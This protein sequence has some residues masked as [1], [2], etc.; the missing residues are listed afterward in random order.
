MGALP[1]PGFIGSEAQGINNKGDIVGHSFTDFGSSMIRA[2]V[3]PAGGVMQDLN[4]LIPRNSG[5]LL[6]WASKIND[7]GQIVGAGSYN[8]A[9]RAYLL[10]PETGRIRSSEYALLVTILFGLTAGEPGGVVIVPGTGPV[11][12]DPEPF[13]QWLRQS[14][15]K[16][17][18]LIGIAMSE[19]ASLA[20][21]VGS[22]QELER[23]ALNMIRRALDDLTRA[24]ESSE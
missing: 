5:W 3:R 9:Y 14:P 18:M 8:G 17:D 21:D 2:F 22:R 6:H 11:P 16:R 15:E 23:S 19:L 4:D 1:L 20:H 13:R 24:N 12:V 7:K 10:T